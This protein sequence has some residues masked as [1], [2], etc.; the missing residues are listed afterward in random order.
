MVQVVPADKGWS[1]AFEQIGKGVS[2]GYQGRA[3]ELAI[4]K[5][6]EGLPEKLLLFRCLC[7]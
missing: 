7:G 5:A 3:D 1:E 2:E 4:Q 6:V